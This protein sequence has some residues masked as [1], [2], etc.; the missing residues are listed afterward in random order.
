MISRFHVITIF[1]SP[2]TVSY[3]HLDVYKRQE[4]HDRVEIPLKDWEKNPQK[5]VCLPAHA[6]P[7]RVKLEERLEK[8]AEYSE[9]SPF[10]RVEMGDTSVGV[11]ASGICYYY[12]KEVWGDKAS[13]LKLGFTNPMPANL[14]KDFCSK[15]DKVYILEENDPY[16]CV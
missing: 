10:N 9:T 3:T 12:A 1:V 8:L 5:Y 13:Y 4:L 14:I 6:R 7:M 15:V 2:W 11:I 16:R